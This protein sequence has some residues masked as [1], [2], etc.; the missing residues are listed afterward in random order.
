MGQDSQRSTLLPYK[1][2]SQTPH[3]LSYHYHAKNTN[4]SS[5]PPFEDSTNQ[6]SQL[7]PHSSNLF[8]K[9]NYHLQLVLHHITKPDH[10]RQVRWSEIRV[11]V[12]VDEYM[13][14]AEK[15][16]VGVLGWVLGKAGEVEFVWGKWGRVSDGTINEIGELLA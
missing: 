11:E 15:V 14:D 1:H 10:M 13:V 5:Y 7:S 3:S 16:D 4:K 12:D 9:S 2:T 8:R 6:Q